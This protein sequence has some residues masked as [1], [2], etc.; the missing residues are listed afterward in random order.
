MFECEVFNRVEAGDHMILIG[1]VVE[2]DSGKK[3]PLLYHKRTFGPIPSS[4]SY[5]ESNNVL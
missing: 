5:I 1:K 3:E 4:K 2:I